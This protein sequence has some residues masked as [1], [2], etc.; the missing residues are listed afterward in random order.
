[1]FIRLAPVTARIKQVHSAI[2]LKLK[3][4]HLTADV[5]SPLIKYTKCAVM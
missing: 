2:N 1:M 4:A 5:L 3:E